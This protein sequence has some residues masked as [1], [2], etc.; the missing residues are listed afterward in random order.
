MR[1]R[2]LFCSAL[3]SGDLISHG[4]LPFSAFIALPTRTAE[5]RTTDARAGFAIGQFLDLS[6]EEQLKAPAS[7]SHVSGFE[8]QGTATLVGPSSP[9]VE[10]TDEYETIF[11]DDEQTPTYLGRGHII[12]ERFASSWYARSFADI[13]GLQ[14]FGSVHQ[15]LLKQQIHVQPTTYIV[16]SDE[17]TSSGVKAEV[18]G[19]FSKVRSD[20]KSRGK[21]GRIFASHVADPATLVE[22]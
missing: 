21:V 20:A 8:L 5:T 14:T 16:A 12:P 11:L 18:S 10:M 4:P 2:E 7:E 1:L 6:G 22:V 3:N 13:S 19:T 9:V 17:A 15:D